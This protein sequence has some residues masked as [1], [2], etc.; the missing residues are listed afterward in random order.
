MASFC[1]HSAA[2]AWFLYDIVAFSNGAFSATVISTVVKNPTLLRTG[3]YQL[4]LGA[5]A[6]PGALLGAFA[7]KFMGTKYLL[8]GGFSGYIVIGLIVG[9]AWD[10]ITHSGCWRCCRSPLSM[11]LAY[12]NAPL[13]T[14]S[15][16]LQSLSSLSFST[17]CLRPSA[18]LAQDLA[19]VS[20][21]PSRIPLHFA[22]QRTVSAPPS[23]R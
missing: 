20:S 16:F 12:P 10:K 5:I 15:F 4:L 22:A 8:V 11:R 1:P 14:N 17:A 23:A 19:W 3:E 9:L 21:P 2:G 6:L 13:S 7:V 18:T